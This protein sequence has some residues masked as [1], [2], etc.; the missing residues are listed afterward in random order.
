MSYRWLKTIENSH[1]EGS[2]QENEYKKSS[3]GSTMHSSC[4]MI[5]KYK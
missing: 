2:K 4:D 3:K 1:F 5:K